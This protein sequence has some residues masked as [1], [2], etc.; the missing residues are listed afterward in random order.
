MEPGLQA[1]LA[2]FHGLCVC[3]RTRVCVCIVCVCVR[4]YV[5]TCCWE[6]VLLLV[7]YYTITGWMDLVPPS[8]EDDVTDQS[9]GPSSQSPG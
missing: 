8:M 5:H 1:S 3:V 9:S 6:E 4:A 7:L 2:S